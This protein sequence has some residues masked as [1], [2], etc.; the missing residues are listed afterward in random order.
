MNAL[1]PVTTAARHLQ[2]DDE[3]VFAEFDGAIAGRFFGFV[4][5]YNRWLM[6]ALAAVALF[7]ASQVAIPLF[8]KWGVD[9]A[10]HGGAALSWILAGFLLIIGTNAIGGYLQERLAAG[11]AQRVIFDLRRA[12]FVR[13]QDVSLSILD[14]THVGRIMSRLQGDVN[15]LQEFLESSVSAIGDFFLLI[16]IITVLLLLDW[17][18]GLLTM[19][20]LPAMIGIRALWLPR[21]RDTFRRAKDA[22]SIV[23][24][25]LAENINGVR[26]VIGARREPLNLAL[27][28]AK[29]RANRDAQ[30]SAAWAAQIMVPTVETL[31]G[32][33]QGLIVLAGGYGILT[34]RIEIGMMVAFIFYVQRFFDPI[35]TLSQQY[36][37]MQR[38]M[39]GAHRIFEVIDVPVLIDDAEDAVPLDT[40]EPSIE[41]RHVT[42]G[43]I[44]G[45]PVL[46]N[47]NFRVEPGQT[48]ALVGPTGSGK[49]S[50]AGLV[51]RFHETW[52]GSVLVGG[53]DVRGVTRASLGRAVAMVL[54]EPFLFSGTVLE[55]IRY[56]SDAADEQVIAAA[57][58][59]GAHDFITKLPQGYATPLTQRGQNFSLGQ[60]QLLSFARA[61]VADPRI[62]ILDEATA[63]IDSFT[64]RDIQ[65]ALK[66]LLKG[67]TSLVIA[68]RLATIRD[69]NAILV[70]Q[71]GRIVERGNHATLLRLGGL[72]SR[73]HAQ[74]GASFDDGRSA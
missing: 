48:L 23:N 27:F 43:Y 19:T 53:Q 9:N 47:L 59:V 18:L 52:D 29:A 11:L 5:P 50:I 2:D 26:A 15:A 65:A 38:A 10:V 54:Q 67:R 37:V 62:L 6:G 68:H 24:A 73:L 33:A 25:A 63:N 14:Q 74:G 4:T 44:P 21:V 61:L 72:Y 40:S 56:A 30:T 8:I 66:L 46:H 16:G 64:E 28:E 39:A 13:L 57:K 41:F 55:N 3:M 45:R 35:T 60:R 31:T 69:A 36:T 20:V 34:G 32:I 58:A 12:M 22:S 17:R 49:T 1:T 71:H 70:V 42:F 7:V 51:K